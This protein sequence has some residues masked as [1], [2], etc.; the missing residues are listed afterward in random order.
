MFLN[1]F[2]FQISDAISGQELYKFCS[3]ERPA[4]LLLPTHEAI[5]RF[6]SDEIGTDL[7]FQLH[8]SAEERLPGC[9][10]V[11]TSKQGTIQSPNYELG[12]GAIS[13]D[14]DIRLAL[15]E[16]ISLDFNIFQLAVDSC[17]ELYDVTP[18]S[19]EGTTAV[20][21]LQSKHCG[22]AAALPPSFHS[23]Y[24]RIRIKFYTAN[25]A[26]TTVDRFELHYH[27]DCSRTYDAAS[28]TITSPGYP[29][30]TSSTRFCT[31]K[32]LTEPNTVITLKR[33]D[34]QLSD[35]MT[36]MSP[37]GDSD[38]AVETG[39]CIGG[40]SLTINDGL[41]RAI[42]GP[43]CGQ[44]LPA[45][46]Y[47]SQTNMLILHLQTQPSSTGRG[48]RFD[49]RAVPVESDRCGGVHTKEGQN[50]R[51]PVDAL[52]NYRNELTCYWIIMAPP[53]KAILLHWLSFQ[54]EGTPDCNYDYV[55]IY[56]G[57]S[58][59]EGKATN[60]IARY[61]DTK[62]PQDLL[63]HARLLTIKFVSDFSD[64]A[65]GFELSYRFVERN[66]CGGHIHAS[67]G[68]LNSPE[69]PLNYTNGLD[70]IWQ[71]TS[72]IGSQ[73][74]LQFDMF[75]LTATRNCSGDW[76]EVRNGRSNSSALIGRYCGTSI[77]RRIPSF[78]HDLY[79]HFHT[80][81]V[82]SARGFR[83]SWH[84]FANGCGGRLIGNE[85]VITSPNYPSTYPHNAQCEWQLRVHSGSSL[86]IVIEDLEMETLDDC[87]YDY[88]RIYSG[89][90]NSR[91]L[92][93]PHF[94]L[95]SSPDENSRVLHVDDNEAVI[96]FHSD[97]SNAD[98]GFRLS[99]STVCQNIVNTTQGVIESIN[100]GEAFFE[101]AINCS[102]QLRPPRGNQIRLEFS[103]FDHRE[104]RLPTDADGGV[105]LIDGAS[106]VPVLG[107]I[108]YSAKAD[109]L[110]IVHNTSSINFRLEYRVDGCV[111]ELRGEKGTF[112]SPKH[113]Q[114]YPN[115]V[116]CYWLIHATPGQVI[117]LTILDMDIE[118]SVNCT[119]DALVVCHLHI[120]A[121]ST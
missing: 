73:M 44:G 7:G 76:L 37:E 41:N 116:E 75:E 52:G 99:Y 18:S 34:F 62:V 32:I 120:S 50:I 48:F 22:G 28:G 63:S 80:D 36:E 86:Q 102:W 2:V 70:C 68:M 51:L 118:E 114:V 85:G 115:D 1:G 3:R 49:Y 87:G 19:S 92:D 57:L 96:V 91:L 53:N 97:I 89:G 65:N 29:N 94:V 47:V 66:S 16:S 71:L 121:S 4:P 42:L 25:T 23:L 95:C 43:Y 56:D 69:Y 105:Y 84:V 12:T 78:T 31:Y 90:S 117:E 6:H 10:G 104:N 72:P 109:N 88:L 61:C 35:R 21:V 54:L 107:L 98:R 15:G 79:L 112:R 20:T 101:G 5:I 9:G 81:D 108:A 39:E 59:G 74:E 103:H 14:Y 119:K 27:M 93:H 46:D 24:N 67:N 38:E 17:I 64:V 113:P 8:Y 45:E 11:Y 58:A 26:S 111:Q 30:L 82:D 110:T 13:C 100:Y 77:P 106:V 83:L 55:E 40:T 33:V 60:A